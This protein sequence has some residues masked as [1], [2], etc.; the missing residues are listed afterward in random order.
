MPTIVRPPVAQ[1]FVEPLV[2]HCS[3]CGK[4]VDLLRRD[5]GFT[6][7]Q[8]RAY[9]EFYGIF[10]MDEHSLE[11]AAEASGL[12]NNDA[13]EAIMDIADW[14]MANSPY[15]SLPRRCLVCDHARGPEDFPFLK[16]G[17]A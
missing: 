3:W 12:S 9:A 6:R 4:E 2:A 7:A 15:R 17:A 11:K 14:L 13:E 16:E 5:S 1:G 8:I 10:G